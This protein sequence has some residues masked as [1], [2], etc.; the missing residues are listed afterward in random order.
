MDAER[1]KLVDARDEATRAWDDAR[2]AL[3]EYDK[4]Q[5]GQ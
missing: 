4:K 1:Q 5:E 2:R 3:R